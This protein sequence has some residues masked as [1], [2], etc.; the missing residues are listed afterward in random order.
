MKSKL[1]SFLTSPWFL[2]IVAA[3]VVA[4]IGIMTLTKSPSP[5]TSESVAT[6]SATGT[7]SAPAN[8]AN[9]NRPAPMNPA[10]PTPTAPANT[11]IMAQPTPME[12]Q[13]LEPWEKDLDAALD[14]NLSDE[15]SV[16]KIL[17]LYPTFPEDGKIEAV[18]YLVDLVED[19][20]YSKIEP[21]LYDK[22]APEEVLETLIDDLYGR[23]EYVQLPAMLKI[24]QDPSHPLYE[25]A[26]EN[27]AD[28]L[29]QDYGNDLAKWQA[30]VDNYLKENPPEPEEEEEEVEE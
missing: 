25:D 19:K 7:P 28:Y 17:T 9:G 10:T 14:D 4:Q 20:D 30:G 22:T 15:Q 16:T 24:M 6:P 8:L 26:K 21:L 11:P 29:E 23:E 13:E 12:P 27:L 3:V 5:N 2:L 1:P 18:E